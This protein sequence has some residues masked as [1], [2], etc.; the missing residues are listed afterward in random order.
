MSVPYKCHCS[1]SYKDM[2]HSDYDYLNS[3]GALGSLPPLY[4]L[5]VLHLYIICT[6]K[7]YELSLISSVLPES[8]L[9]GVLEFFPFY[10]SVTLI[11]DAVL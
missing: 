11:V 4:D 2:Y 1:E 3:A 5:N 10:Q 8:R 9:F 7:S 6:S